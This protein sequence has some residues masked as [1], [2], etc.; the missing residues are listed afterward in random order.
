MS[1]FY[2]VNLIKEINEVVLARF[3]K[4]LAGDPEISGKEREGEG[5]GVLFFFFSFL[6][7]M[8]I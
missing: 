1:I 3:E 4:C 8:E 7:K 2:N 6:M 5:E